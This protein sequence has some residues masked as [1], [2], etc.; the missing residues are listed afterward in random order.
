MCLETLHKISSGSSL[1]FY[2]P[3]MIVLSWLYFPVFNKKWAYPGHVFFSMLYNWQ[4]NICRC[5]DSNHGS[6][7]SEVTTLPTV[8]QPLPNVLPS[9]K[10]LIGWANLHLSDLI[11]S[12]RPCLPA[13]NGARAKLYSLF[14]LAA[15]WN[16]LMAE[17]VLD[18]K[19]DAVRSAII[20]VRA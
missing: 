6:L 20:N 3:F 18:R 16:S 13:P 1:N 4:V 12:S 10:C 5:W 7:V 17:L 15:S 11:N 8:L 9:L 14:V 19:D 2:L